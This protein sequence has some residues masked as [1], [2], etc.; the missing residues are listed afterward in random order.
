MDKKQEYYMTPREAVERGF[1]DAVL[2]DEGYETI[3]M[4]RGK[5]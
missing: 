5:K 4:I 1:M 2:G 3:E